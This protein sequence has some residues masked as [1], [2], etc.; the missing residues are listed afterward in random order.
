MSFSKPRLLTLAI[1]CFT[2]AIV[3]APRAR[4]ATCGDMDCGKGFT[5]VTA[6]SVEPVTAPAP[7]KADCPLD[8]P[9]AV[10]DPI[11]P[12]VDAGTSAIDAGAPTD[13][14][15]CVPAS[16]TTD[17]D[18]GVGMVC[19]TSTESCG[20]TAGACAAGTKCDPVPS[21]VCSGHSISFCEYKSALPCNVDADCGDGFT[22]MPSVGGA[23]A[24]GGG[25]SNAGGAA[26]SEPNMPVPAVDGGSAPHD[27][28]TTTTTFPGY[29]QAKIK[30][31]ATTTDCPAAWTCASQALDGSTVTSGP[32]TA[33]DG[34]AASNSSAI[35]P[36][37]PAPSGTTP[38]ATTLVCTPPGGGYLSPGEATNTGD[39]TGTPTTT[40]GAAGTHG[41]GTTTTGADPQ[42]AGSGSASTSNAGCALGGR[43]GPASLG[44]TVLALLG[45][46]V[47][48]R[49]R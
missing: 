23:C 18:C 38:P 15:L 42:A 46:A 33:S 26:A 49:R 29:C 14:Y 36:G 3:A 37:E 28:C 20:E 24:G 45:L 4:A 19:H 10:A 34:G 5:C 21:T 6:P 2:V 44:L 27:T 25:T 12:A 16:C 17:G 48:R 7:A 22:C 39:K 47:A 8:A 43:P 11:A 30:T 32:A 40:T 9:C 1:G 41:G 13:Q 35:A 31:C